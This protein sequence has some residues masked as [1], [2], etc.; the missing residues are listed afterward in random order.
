MK[1]FSYGLIVC[2]AVLVHFACLATFAW[3]NVLCFDLWW[4]IRYNCNLKNSVL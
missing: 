1:S 3:L 4:D 2:L